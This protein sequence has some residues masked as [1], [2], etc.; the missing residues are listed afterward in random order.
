MTG[1]QTCAL[2]ISDAKPAVTHLRAIER[3][4]RGHALVEARLETGRT[5]QVR[6]HLSELGH[7]VVGDPLYDTPR[8]GAGRLA[9]HAFHL[10]FRHPV[11]GADPQPG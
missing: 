9:L 11:T 4:G 1:V 5:H 8:R 10:G 6:I 3:V 2:P 7:P